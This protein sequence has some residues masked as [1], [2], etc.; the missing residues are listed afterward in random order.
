MEVIL[1]K[2]RVTNQKGHTLNFGH[3]NQTTHIKYTIAWKIWIAQGGNTC[4]AHGSSVW[5]SKNITFI[6]EI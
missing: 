4:V 6:Q 2:Q 1:L 3:K 5:A